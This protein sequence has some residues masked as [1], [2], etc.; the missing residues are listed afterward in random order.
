[1]VPRRMS[2]WVL[3]LLSLTC[4]VAFLRDQLGVALESRSA[5][6]SCASSPAIIASACLICGLDLAAVEREQ[7]IAL[8]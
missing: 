6:S 3:A 5:P 4:V 2:T 7:Q 8:A 1:M